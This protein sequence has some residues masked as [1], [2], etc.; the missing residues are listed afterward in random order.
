MKTQEELNILK[1]EV[2]SLSEKLA[3][4]SEEELNQVSGGIMPHIC[5]SYIYQLLT[6]EGK[7]PE[8]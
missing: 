8:E 3:G 1:E 6:P 4:L 7:K 2:K 5:S